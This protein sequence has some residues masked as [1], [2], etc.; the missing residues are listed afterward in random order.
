MAK[1]KKRQ[2]ISIGLRV[3]RE[4]LALKMSEDELARAIGMTVEFIRKLESDEI[5]D[6]GLDVL[7]KLARALGTTIPSLQGIST[8]FRRSDSLPNGRPAK[9]QKGKH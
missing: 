5:L 9:V 6:I 8:H 4:R 2:K 7:A 3:R 1:R